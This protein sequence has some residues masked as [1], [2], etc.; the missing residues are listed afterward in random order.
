M[1]MDYA[2]N[3]HDVLVAADKVDNYIIDTGDLAATNL[4]WTSTTVQTYEVPASKRWLLYGGVVTRDTSTGTATLVVNLT[5]GTNVLMNLATEADATG[6]TSLLADIPG[7]Y[8]MPLIMDA[9][10]QVVITFGEAQGAAA[11]ATCVVLEFDV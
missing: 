1:P 5:D 2:V 7:D 9:G 3:P 8:V 6:T 4:K 11:A 10:D